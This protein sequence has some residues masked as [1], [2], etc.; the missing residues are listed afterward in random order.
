MRHSGK[1]ELCWRSGGDFNRASEGL[2]RDLQE[3]CGVAKVEP[4]FDP[5]LAGFNTGIR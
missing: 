3:L 5:S 2:G 4:E 1:F